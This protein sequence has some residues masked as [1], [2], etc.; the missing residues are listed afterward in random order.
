MSNPERRADLGTST[1]PLAQPSNFSGRFDPDPPQPSRRTGRFDTSPAEPSQKAGHSDSDDEESAHGPSL[2][3]DEVLAAAH[4][5]PA[6]PLDPAL[7]VPTPERPGLG[8]RVGR[9]RRLQAVAATQEGCFTVSQAR[10]AGLNRGARYHH[11]SYGNWRHTVAPGVF[12]LSH[13]PDDPHENFRAWLLWAGSGA[14]LTSWSALELLGRTIIGPN[15]TVDLLLG[16]HP[17][18]RSDRRRSV[19]HAADRTTPPAR[20]HHVRDV[21]LADLTVSGMTVRPVEE[22]L[23]TALMTAPSGSVMERLALELILREVAADAQARIRLLLTARSM[24]AT[25]LTEL[26]YDPRVL[27]ERLAARSE[28]A[29]YPGEETGL[30]P[31]GS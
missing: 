7:P 1:P 27:A 28:P 24:S 14:A 13:W 4:F 18:W 15:S 20:L 25:R 29:T 17:G 19:P 21:E 22:A 9:R 26:I 3:V 11:L 2:S 31:S 8:T 16:P 6:H 23:A 12:R 30:D 10:D 5:P